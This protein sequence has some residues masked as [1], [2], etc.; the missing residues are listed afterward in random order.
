MM[1]DGRSRSD[2]IHTA[3][4]AVSIH[5]SLTGEAIDPRHLIPARYRPPMPEPPKKTEAEEKRETQAALKLMESFI[6][7]G[8]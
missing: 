5:R 2:W 4:L 3:T 1:A 8:L 6:L 7:Q